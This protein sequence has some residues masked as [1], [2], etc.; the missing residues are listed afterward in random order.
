MKATGPSAG[1]VLLVDHVSGP[2]VQP[3]SVQDGAGCCG[4]AMDW[5]PQLC[6]KLVCD[7]R[8]LLAQLPRPPIPFL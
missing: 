1:A 6:W 5:A 3:A 8:K 7:L 2:P 4:K